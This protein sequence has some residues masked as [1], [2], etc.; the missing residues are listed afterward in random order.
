MKIREKRHVSA[1]HKHAF[2]AVGLILELFPSSVTYFLEKSVIC[3]ICFQNISIIRFLKNCKLLYG[4]IPGS[5]EMPSYHPVFWSPLMKPGQK[6]W[7]SMTK[8]SLFSSEKAV[9]HCMLWYN[10]VY[11]TTATRKRD[12]YDFSKVASSFKVNGLL[13]NDTLHCMLDEIAYQFIYFLFL[14]IV[15]YAGRV[16]GC[17]NE[18]KLTEIRTIFSKHVDGTCSD[19]MWTGTKK[20]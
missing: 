18:L 16:T 8:Q 19:R 17:M 9:L 12:A 2:Q 6:A 14:F 10:L 13:S 20:E 1:R 5:E 3:K 4:N 7:H 11:K 15:E